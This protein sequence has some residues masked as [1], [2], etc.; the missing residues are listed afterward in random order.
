MR[1]H[2]LD[3]SVPVAFPTLPL[4]LLGRF[5]LVGACLAS[6]LMRLVLFAL[7][8]TAPAALLCALPRP[9][10]AQNMVD[11]IVFGSCAKAMK[12]DFQKANKTP[13]EGMVQDTCSCVVDRI[14]LRYSIEQ[15]KQFCTAQSVQKYGQI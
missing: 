12:A 8:M 3:V 14:N 11:Q 1:R 13:P 9:A 5:D 2:Q 10:Q 4:A 15:A 7:A 6:R